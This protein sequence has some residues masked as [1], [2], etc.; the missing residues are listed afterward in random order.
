MGKTCIGKQD[1]C[2]NDTSN[3]ER[4]KQVIRSY[5]VYEE[6][7]EPRKRKIVLEPCSGENDLDKYKRQNICLWLGFSPYNRCIGDP[8]PFEALL[9]EWKLLSH[10]SCRSPLEFKLKAKSPE[11]QAERN[12]L[13]T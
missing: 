13:S 11:S 12:A 4:M 9:L 5:R 1:N 6:F 7:K 2:P 3:K 10:S 8:T